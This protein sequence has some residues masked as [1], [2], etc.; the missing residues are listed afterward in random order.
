MPSQ[1]PITLA[2]STLESLD[3]ASTSPSTKTILFPFYSKKEIDTRFFSKL[4]TYKTL[5][6]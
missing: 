3:Q 2:F 4:G 1:V 6:K 5:L